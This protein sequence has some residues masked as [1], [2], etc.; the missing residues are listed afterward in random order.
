MSFFFQLLEAFAVLVPD[1]LTLG[2]VTSAF[3]GLCCIA[4][5]FGTAGTVDH[6]LPFKISLAFG[7]LVTITTNIFGTLAT[8]ARSTITRPSP[9]E[10]RVEQAGRGSLS[11]TRKAQPVGREAAVL[12]P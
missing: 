11:G 3:F 8:P 6:D 4:R 7:Y 5:T 10:S 12:E 9:P 1:A 2:L